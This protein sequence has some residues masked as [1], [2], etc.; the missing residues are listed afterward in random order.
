MSWT[1]ANADLPDGV[2]H[3]V[4][5]P[6]KTLKYTW[7]H[8]QLYYN[9]VYTHI[10]SHIISHIHV[11]EEQKVKREKRNEAHRKMKLTDLYYIGDKD[12]NHCTT[13]EVF[14]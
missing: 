3:S 5:A 7:K 12:H 1:S 2:L 13:N 11:K 14:N 10:I 8:S 4:N 6:L 9:K